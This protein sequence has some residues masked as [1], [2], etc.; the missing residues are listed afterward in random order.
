[1]QRIKINIVLLIVLGGPL[2]YFGILRTISAPNRDWAIG[3]A[4]LYLIPLILML[5]KKTSLKATG[6]WIGI[7]LILDF[8][9]SVFIYD[10]NYKTLPPHMDQRFEV[11]GDVMPGFSGVEHVT[12]DE[13]GF[14]VT[15]AINYENKPKNT[16]RVFAIGGS[17]TEQI[18]L[19]DHETWTHLLQ[20]KL[21]KAYPDKQVEVINTGLSGL[22]AAQHLSTLKMISRFQ[23]DMI[24]FLVGVNDWNRQIRMA[25]SDGFARQEYLRPF[26]PKLSMIGMGVDAIRAMRKAA[27]AAKNKK[28]ATALKK[29]DGAYYASVNHSFENREKRDFAFNG[30]S[31]EYRK[32]MQDIISYCKET[33]L[34]CV[35]LTQPHGYQDGAEQALIDRFWMTPPMEDYT[36]GMVAM[37]E[38]AN[39]YNVELLKMAKQAS[40]KS[41]DLAAGMQPSIGLFY[42]DCHYNE[43]GAQK[44][45]ALI[46][47]CVIK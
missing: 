10:H 42:D 17:T 43:A 32:T 36:V 7:F 22:R 15:R 13:M 23:P 14:R 27:K 28:N 25:L 45:A 18:Y 4:V 29:V 35:L 39:A 30:V 6:V 2:L 34:D 46:T 20:E 5:L 40:V 44:M 37:Q 19:D 24:L 12:T 41:C 1:M 47:Q 11:V 26:S 38:I 9:Y 16:L 21:Q 8:V 31:N 33:D 3:A